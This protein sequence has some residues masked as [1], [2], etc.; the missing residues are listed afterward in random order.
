[1]NL[2][3]YRMLDRRAKDRKADMI[4][5]QRDRH[6]RLTGLI[7]ALASLRYTSS[8]S[9]TN[10]WKRFELA[11][12]PAF[13]NCWTKFLQPLAKVSATVTGKREAP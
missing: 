7:Q 5:R 9:V 13:A 8:N 11:H 12:S 1:M 3:T 4:V 6:L 10:F 2:R